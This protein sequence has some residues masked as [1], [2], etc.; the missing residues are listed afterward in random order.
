MNNMQRILRKDTNEDSQW[1]S[2]VQSFWI[3]MN[4]FVE[5]MVQNLKDSL[6]NDAWNAAH[7]NLRFLTDLVNC[8]VVAANSL[9]QLLDNM[10]DVAKEEGGPSVFT[11]SFIYLRQL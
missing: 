1:N 9:L 4:K 2:Y 7:Y 3:T 6:K 11:H 5:H 8:H 10:L